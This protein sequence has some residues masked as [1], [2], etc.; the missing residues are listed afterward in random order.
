MLF[1]GVS[2]CVT[3]SFAILVC[4]REMAFDFSLAERV[5][6]QRASELLAEEEVRPRS[7]SSSSV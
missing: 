3:T 2:R 1:L 6:Q 5:R 7:Y 4:I